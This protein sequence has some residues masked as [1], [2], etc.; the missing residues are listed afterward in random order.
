[1]RTRRNRS[2]AVS[3]FIAGSTGERMLF[4][5]S[6]HLADFTHDFVGGVSASDVHIIVPDFGETARASGDQ[7]IGRLGSIM[8]FVLLAQKIFDVERLPFA[9]IER[10]N[11]FVDLG[12]QAAQ[13]L[14]V[15][16]QLLTDLLLIRVRQIRH[17]R[18]H[19]FERSHHGGIVAHHI[20]RAEPVAVS[21]D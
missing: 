5:Q 21:L 12:S 2:K 17:F 11:A 9:G 15:R 19:F 4:K 6:A 14:D 1:M 7:S 18:Y 20:S 13:F 16:Q 10:A 3:H 8:P